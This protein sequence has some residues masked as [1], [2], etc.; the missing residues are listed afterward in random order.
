MTY[1][2]ID[3]IEGISFAFVSEISGIIN[4]RIDK[5]SINKMF[6]GVCILHTR[7]GAYSCLFN[8][9]PVFFHTQESL[10]LESIA[11]QGIDMYNR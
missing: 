8:V 11:M 4:I 5:V 2:Q 9:N 7:H 1:K 3:S 6:E 10:C